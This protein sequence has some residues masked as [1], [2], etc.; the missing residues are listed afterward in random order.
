MMPSRPAED[1]A[2][3]DD[4]DVEAR[5]R[6]F[7]TQHLGLELGATVRFERAA[8]RRLVDG[9]ALRDAEHRARRRVHDLA[10]LGPA[11][12]DEQRGSAA[13]VHGVE[14]GT[15]LGQRYLRD[16]VK[17]DVD[18]FAGRVRRALVAD[19][20]GNILGCVDFGSGRVQV[21]D[22][23]RVTASERTRGQ[24]TPK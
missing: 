12:G 2:R 18:A 11:R 17:D 6:G 14:Q 10:H 16:V 15:V 13:D 24:Q 19:V 1:R 9:V 5:R 22:A 3:P 4:R 7:V 23:D 21:E 8:R 20:A